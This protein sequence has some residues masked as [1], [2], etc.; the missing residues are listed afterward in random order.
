M[1]KKIILFIV[2]ASILSTTYLDA[3]TC[4]C[5]TSD[6]S[7]SYTVPDNTPCKGSKQITNAEL[8][9]YDEEGGSETYIITPN[10]ASTLCYS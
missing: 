3:K 4:G 7:A 2:C 1:M 10:F 8:T 6:W 5:K 9:V